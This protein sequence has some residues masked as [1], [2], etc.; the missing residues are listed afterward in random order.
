MRS[1]GGE[2]ERERVDGR[3]LATLAFR[4]SASSSLPRS[5]LFNTF[6]RIPRL[7]PCPRPRPRGVQPSRLS[8]TD[9]AVRE[10][11]GTRMHGN[12]ISPSVFLPL[13][14]RPP[15]PSFARFNCII[16]PLCPGAE[17][18]RERP[19][20]PAAPVRAAP[21]T[22]TFRGEK[23]SC[24]ARS[25]PRRLPGTLGIRCAP[26]PTPRVAAIAGLVSVGERWYTFLTSGPA[27]RFQ[28][29]I[30]A[31]VAPRYRSFCEGNV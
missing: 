18:A 30:R 21:I 24:G 19:V 23:N 28:I 9:A 31:T 14:G 26:R 5:L 4:A 16:V 17:G 10:L 3:C 27:I 15:S 25:G 11:A 22:A 29:V 13:A 7:G 8:M 2:R 12:S 20:P 6:A 1:L